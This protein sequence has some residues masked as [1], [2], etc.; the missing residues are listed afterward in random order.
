MKEIKSIPLITEKVRMFSPETQAWIDET[1][2][3]D[4]DKLGISVEDYR[5]YLRD[6]E[7]VSAERD[8][9][10]DVQAKS[11]EGQLDA[12]EEWHLRHAI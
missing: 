5:A 11:R 8:A 10:F 7:V 9:Q 2:S 3:R 12:E 6:M 4:A 1:L